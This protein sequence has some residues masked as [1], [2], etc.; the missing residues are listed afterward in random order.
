[1]IRRVILDTGPLVAFLKQD[2]SYHA[3]SVEQFQQ[4]ERPLVTCEAV[5]SEACFLLGQAPAG[6]QKIY[7]FLERGDLVL[8][9]TLPA[10]LQRVFNLMHTYR[11]VPMSLADACLVCMAENVPDS[12][13]FTL[14]RDFQVYRQH[15]HQLISVII[16]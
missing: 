11:D 6:V 9:F 5:I 1:M 14:D 4:I 2:E 3:W 8:D 12:R 15:R 10:N 16:S 13:V 7:A